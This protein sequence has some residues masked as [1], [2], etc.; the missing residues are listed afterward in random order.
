[1]EKLPEK[2]WERNLEGTHPLHTS[3]T[4]DTEIINQYFA[5][6]LSVLKG[7]SVRALLMC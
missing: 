1:M 4:P 6:L 3:I 7:S 5:I 2:T